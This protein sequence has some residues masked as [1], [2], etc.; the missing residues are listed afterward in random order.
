MIN[1]ICFLIWFELIGLFF[2]V[3]FFRLC[4]FRLCCFLMNSL[5]FV[6]ERERLRF[7]FSLDLSFY[8]FFYRV[9][10]KD[11]F[12][13]FFYGFFYFDG[14]FVLIFLW[15]L[16]FYERGYWPVQYQSIISY[17]PVQYQS[18]IFYWPV[19]LFSLEEVI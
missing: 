3:V 6:G 16:F 5:L 11:F 10:F 7:F 15:T 12:P 1:S 14:F 4:F 18:I 17:W 2:E 13:G 19:P 8:F 9:F